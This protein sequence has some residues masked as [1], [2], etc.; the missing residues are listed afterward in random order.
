MKHGQQ[1]LA[2]GLAY[3]WGV[4][5]VAFAL[6]LCQRW[7]PC[8]PLWENAKGGGGSL[9]EPGGRSKWAMGKHAGEVCGLGPPSFQMQWR[10]TEQLG[11][12]GCGH[13]GFGG[14]GKRCFLFQF[15]FVAGGC[16]LEIEPGRLIAE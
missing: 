14:K 15:C 9:R 13:F 1:R 2:G 11:S 16:V 10:P 7:P 8:R 5:L 3:F 4:W 6:A 12:G